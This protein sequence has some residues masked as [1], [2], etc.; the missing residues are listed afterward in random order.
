MARH[1]PP[2]HPQRD[3]LYSELHARPAAHI[4]LPAFIL[5]IAVLNEAVPRNAELAHLQRLPG[6]AHLGLADLE[7]NFLRLQLGNYSLKWERHTEFTRYSLVLPLPAGTDMG[8]EPDALRS[9][10]GLNEDWLSAIPGPNPRRFF[11]PPP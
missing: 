8:Q 2:D 11:A 4:G 9:A 10:L 6:Q 3:Q 5:L 1:L 7:S